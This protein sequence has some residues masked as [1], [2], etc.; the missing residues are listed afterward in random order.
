MA[1]DVRIAISCPDRT[2]LLS[3]LTGRLFDLGADMGDASFA[4]LG[5]AAEFATVARLPD[6]VAAADVHNALA[7]LPELE[8]AEISVTAFALGVTHG[9][10]AHVTHRIEVRGTDRPGL[11]ARLTEAFAEDYVIRIEAWIPEARAETCLAAVDN[12]AQSLGLSSSA[13]AI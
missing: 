11:V 12:T 8:G 4:V 10:S 13:A 5:E 3:A 1:H 7:A 2:G 9:E 6:S